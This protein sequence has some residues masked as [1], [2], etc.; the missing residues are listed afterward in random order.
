M[1]DNDIETADRLG[2]RRARALPIL[3]VVFT[4]QQASFIATRLEDGTRLVDHVKIGAWLVLTIVLLLALATKGF[5]FHRQSVRA[6]V[7][8]EPTRSNRTEA[9][10]VGFIAAM[11]GAIALYG[12]TFLDEVSGRDA[13]H[14]VTTVGIAAALLRFGFLER[15]AHR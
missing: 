7:D 11:I 1:R 2:R 13:I 8:D 15:R 14:I 10:R 3:A 6:L 12:L 9:M 5:W 4:S